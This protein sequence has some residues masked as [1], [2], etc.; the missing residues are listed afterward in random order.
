MSTTGWRESWSL[1]SSKRSKT[2]RRLLPLL[3]V[4]LLG[5]LLG[6]CVTTGGTVTA[7]RSELNRQARCAGW[8]EGSYSHNDTLQTQRWFMVYDGVGRRKKCWR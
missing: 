3:V 2:A 6:A 7:G 8:P 4:T 1:S 5:P